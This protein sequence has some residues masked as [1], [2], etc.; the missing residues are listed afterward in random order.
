M[1]KILKFKHL[2]GFMIASAI[3]IV[4]GLFC[5]Y[6]PTNN[7]SLADRLLIGEI[8]YNGE[9]TH[10]GEHTASSVNGQNFDRDV[11]Y[12]IVSADGYD[13][14][15]VTPFSHL[16]LRLFRQEGKGEYF[17]ITEIDGQ[18]SVSFSGNTAIHYSKARINHV[19]NDQISF[20]GNTYKFYDMNSK[21]TSRIP[22]G[23]G[24]L[25]ETKDNPSSGTEVGG[26]LQEG[27]VF[28]YNV[29][30]TPVNVSSKCIVEFENLN[31]QYVEGGEIG[32]FE[33]T[34]GHIFNA[35]ASSFLSDRYVFNGW[36]HNGEKVS[37][38]INATLVA[39]M[40]I[41]NDN[42]QTNVFYA[43]FDE[44]K[45]KVVFHSNDDRNLLKEQSFV[46]S[47]EQNLSDFTFEKTGF[48]FIGWATEPDGEVVY[49][50]CQNV[51]QLT[52]VHN[53]TVNLYA[54][55]E[56][57]Q[58]K[59]N[60]VQ[61]GATN[62]GT[63]ETIVT[64]D[65]VMPEIVPP[66]KEGFLFDGY[67]DQPNGKGKRYYDYLGKSNIVCDFVEDITLYAY[68][69]ET[70]YS[71]ATSK[72]FVLDSD[73]YL[74]IENEFDLASLSYMV[75]VENFET[76]EKKFK[77]TQN[78]NLA[79]KL[80]LPIGTNENYF[81][82]QFNG[83]EKKISNVKTLN[84][85]ERV[86]EI[87]GAGL[88]G[89]AENSVISNV[90]LCDVN[91]QGWDNVGAI[92]G[93]MSGGQIENCQVES[94]FVAGKVNVGGLAGMLAGSSRINLSISKA[95]VRCEND[96]AGGIVGSL[97]NSNIESCVSYGNIA[98]ANY[99]GG[100]AGKMSGTS[101]IERTIN[102]GALN[103]NIVGGALGKAESQSFFSII[104][105]A[106]YGDLTGNNA[107]G[108]MIGDAL[109]AGANCLI[110]FSS[111]H[112]EVSKENTSFVGSEYQGIII[113]SYLKADTSSTSIKQASGNAEE[114]SEGFRYKDGIN[115]SL[116]M[117]VE[118]FKIA[119][120]IER[121]E[122]VLSNGLIDFEVIY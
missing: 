72:D 37:S 25:G 39:D 77:L 32:N 57:V 65:S 54:R 35:D 24:W 30:A 74:I 28:T 22:G 7:T 109:N 20:D 21:F 68:F 5:L 44:K 97:E 114:F 64:F 112:S 120:A 66:Q 99:G 108:A 119:S 40:G 6:F 10:K 75:N 11:N 42:N 79:G 91:I 38:N 90:K 71:V 121:Q 55:Y 67:F 47:V 61:T 34:Y 81:K 86:Q 12:T 2:L 31:G 93:R 33:T 59:V 14:K 3:V 41:K 103:G 27:W 29:T 118:L 92:V 48:N 89:N 62:L 73:G 96:F 113:G 17:D 116:P 76:A 8:I 115:N 1:N 104:S 94:G 98:S 82:G 110:K 106:N 45:Y 83:C 43:R 95:N 63:E 26:D 53:S 87:D 56:A 23:I 80:W 4:A 78:I 16:L 51:Q 111:S 100:I 15:I 60:F 101:T 52:N 19:M 102:K 36:F 105:F 88:F 49:S 58:S 84:Y 46:Y 107:V 69:V 70:W 117:Q 13:Y 85:L 9:I 50:D 18:K 122:D